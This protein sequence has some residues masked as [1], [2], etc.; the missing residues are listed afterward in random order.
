MDCWSSHHCQPDD[1]HLILLYA[2]WVDI[3][4]KT[5][6]CYP[7]WLHIRDV[8]YNKEIQIFDYVEMGHLNDEYS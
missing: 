1:I 4:I 6:T 8:D 3:A 7:G 2:Q 5:N